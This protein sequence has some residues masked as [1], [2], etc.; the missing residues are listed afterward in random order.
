MARMP[1]VEICISTLAMFIGL[2][3]ATVAALPL[4]TRNNSARYT[5][6]RITRSTRKIGVFSC[7]RNRLNA[8]LEAH[9]TLPPIEYFNMFSSVISPF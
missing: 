5:A 7:F 3:N 6:M 4:R 2:V 9:S 8:V 1:V